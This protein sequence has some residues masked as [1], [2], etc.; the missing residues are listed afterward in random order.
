MRIIAGKHRGRKLLE[1]KHFKK[2]LRPTSDKNR[3]NLFNVLFSSKKIKEIGFEITDSN[4]LDVFSGSGA[5]AL[6]ALS[7]GAK[8][9]ALVDKNRDHLDLSKENFEL[10]GEKNV[11][12]F[13]VDVTKSVFKNNRQYNLIFI[14]PPYYK[15]LAAKALLNLT[16]SGWIADNSLIIIEHSLDENLDEIKQKFELLEERKYK[17]MMFS[18]FVHRSK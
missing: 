10:L 11:E 1:S 18:F 7:R 16:E 13:C 14:D 5:V 6:E 12:F 4:F 17:D 9:A 8:S 2:D 15:N 3:E